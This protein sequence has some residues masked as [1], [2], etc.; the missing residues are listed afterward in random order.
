MPTLRRVLP[1]LLLLASCTPDEVPLSYG[2]GDGSERTHRLTLR[3]QIESELSGRP[4]S[5][6]VQASFRATQQVLETLPDGGSRARMT[7]TPETLAVDGQTQTVGEPQEFTVTLASDGRVIQIEE[8]TGQAAEPL[9]PVGIER[10]LPRLRPVLPGRPVSPG[11]TWRSAS[12]FS[13]DAGSFS[14]SFRSRLDQ[15]GLVSGRAAALVRTTY[16]SPMQRR[17]I[18][19][20]AV[21]DVDGRDVGTQEA[22]FAL[23]G[24][25]LR[26][27]GDSVGRYRVVFRL[28]GGDTGVAPVPGS[29]LVRLHTEMRLL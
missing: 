25:L 22:W 8:A 20:N 24:D 4:R 17:E 16:E 7:L 29:L 23:D 18:F 1:L 15:L 5:Q 19:A 9:T 14:L 11:D 27:T 21:A 28:P 2:T 12:R 6:T 10:L 13:D 3:A 26:A